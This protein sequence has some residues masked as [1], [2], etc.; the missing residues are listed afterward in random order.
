MDLDAT[1]IRG[2]E[3]L[4]RAVLD[5]RRQTG[6]TQRQLGAIA[7]V[8]QSTISGLERGRLTGIRLQVLGAILAA[9]GRLSF[10][11]R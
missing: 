5:A 1:V 2:L 6:L 3:I 8:H 10:A 11:A 9:L 4:G 7:G